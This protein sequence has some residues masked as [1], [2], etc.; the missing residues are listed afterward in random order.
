M[1]RELPSWVG[2][3]KGV[4]ALLFCADCGKFLFIFSFSV[5]KSVHP[6]AEF[7]IIMTIII[8]S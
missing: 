4:L 5:M 7:L 3:A 8:F 1:G 6:A 2:C